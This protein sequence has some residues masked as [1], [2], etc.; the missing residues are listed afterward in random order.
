MSDPV[1]I[2]LK[3][4]DVAVDLISQFYLDVEVEEN[5]FDVFIDI[6][7]VIYGFFYMLLIVF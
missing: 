3:N 7:I 2:L 5:K 1:K 4:T 6:Y